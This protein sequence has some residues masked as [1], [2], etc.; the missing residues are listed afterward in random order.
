M[1]K[2]GSV[3]FQCAILTA[4]KVED[5]VFVCIVILH[6]GCF[7]SPRCTEFCGFTV[8][9]AISVTGKVKGRY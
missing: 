5:C 1:H 3:S 6:G 4:A 8:A 9:C 7:Y 2:S